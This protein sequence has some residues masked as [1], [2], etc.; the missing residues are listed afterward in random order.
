M[1]VGGP[2]R[3]V[4]EVLSGLAP[5]PGDAVADLYCG[6]GLFTAAIAHAVGPTGSVVGIDASVEAI[7]D[8]RRN[9]ATMPWA[10]VI[11]ARVDGR[12]VADE[13]SSCTT[14]V[15]D[16]PRRG[17]DRGALDALS[18]IGS[19]R[20]IVSVS[21]DPSTFARDLRILLDAGWRL[22]DVHAL[23]LFEMT[24]HV[25]CVATLER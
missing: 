24:E 9:V 5:T 15:L 12:A 2:E 21:C 6:A 8:A 11:A 3:L 22:V 19:L 16:P 14:C 1:H 25:E 23:D 4:A 7:D 13:A 17:A 10:R 18:G 20:R